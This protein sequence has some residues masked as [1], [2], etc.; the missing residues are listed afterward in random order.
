MDKLKV[1]MLAYADE[2]WAGG[3]YYI[4]SMIDCLN[5]LSDEQKPKISIICNENN[6]NHFKEY[7]S[8]KNCSI[9]IIKNDQSKLEKLIY[10]V[11]GLKC[12]NQRLA[13]LLN[14]ENVD[15][16]FPVV[17][18]GFYQ[19]K[20]TKFIHWYPDFQHLHL[21][22][23]FSRLDIF[24][25]NRCIHEIAISS[26]TLILSSNNAYKD[27]K[28]NFKI[29][30]NKKV[31]VQP[32]SSSISDEDILCDSEY[33]YESY[34]IKGD[35]F[36]I[37]NQF[38]KHK[39]HLTA[40]KAVNTLVKKHKK[41]VLLL[42]S[43]KTSDQ[44][45]ENYFSELQK[46]IYEYELEEHIKIV[47]FIPRKDQVQMMKCAKAIIQ[48]SLFEGWSTVVEDAKALKKNIIL[49]EIDV[50][51]EQNPE[52]ALYFSPL[53]EKEL[54]DCMLKIMDATSEEKTNNNFSCVADLKALKKMYGENLLEIFRLS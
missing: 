43:G 25:R 8:L 50:H 26:N 54:V 23:M 12:H 34:N 17:T 47:G 9:H 27:L 30:K 33:I 11:L 18:K 10:G 32:F 15:V 31:F 38:W 13:R 48:P 20:R 45:N 16:L 53:D 3:I 42:C 35:F 6:A 4:K 14:K 37:P 1:G 41:N 36:F 39:N 7:E 28:D 46:Y 44:R 22:E 2:N 19:V 52:N 40:F 5:T 21:P 51:K 24:Y 29:G 49:S